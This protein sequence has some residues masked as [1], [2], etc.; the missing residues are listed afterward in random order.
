MHRLKWLI[1]GMG[2]KRWIFMCIVGLGLIIGGS[3]FLPSE[4]VIFKSA[5]LATLI[6]GIYLTVISIRE[7][8]RFFIGILLP[9][10]RGRE[11]VDIVYAKRQLSKGPNIVT[12]GGGTGLSVLLHGLKKYTNNI[13]AIVTVS[14][15][16]GSSGR[17]SEEFG[18]LPPGDIRNCLVALAE[19]EPLMRDL[20]QFRFKENSELAGHNFGNLFITAM[21]ELTGDF[22]KAIKASS[23]VLAIRGQ[24]IPSTLKKVTL[25][26]KDKEG[27]TVK[28]ETEITKNEGHIDKLYLD[29]P[30]CESTNEVRDAI[31]HAHVIIL[32]PGSLYTS[33]ISNLLIKDIFK[34]IIDS[35]A[36]KIYV[37][38][39][40]T[41]S[42]ETDGYSASDH[43][44]AIISH[45]SPGLIDYVIVN[46]QE[47]TREFSDKYKKENAYPVLSDSENIRKMG[48]KVIEDDVVS[49]TDHV[50]HN[51]EKLSKIIIDLI[52]KS[53]ISNGRDK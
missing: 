1:P 34:G 24:V 13:S 20:F 39:V 25:M 26:A 40:M 14:D 16:G 23:K 29:P 31:S 22:D 33:I 53:K 48:Y 28:G 37:C 4:N 6:F 36:L 51:S 5:G 17:L 35:R 3:F 18:L 10:K 12:I 21:T 47:I 9:Q 15:D 30:H 2:I 38:N 44:K 46:T 19:A 50:R 32:G 43:V 52:N 41:Q 49:A 42:H 7:M 27:H 11:L 45:G 8:M